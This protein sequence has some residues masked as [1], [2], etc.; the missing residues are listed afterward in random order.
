M[1]ITPLHFGL[2]PL[3]NRV[4]RKRMSE[5][6]FVLAN[7]L[8]DVPVVI[9]VLMQEK[10]EMGGPVLL[11][12]LHGVFTHNFTGALAMGLVLGLLGFRSARWWLGCLLGTMTHVGLDMFV[13]SDVQPFMPWISGNPFYIDG[14]HAV[15]SIVLLVGCSMWV[16]ESWDRMKVS[17]AK[18]R[19]K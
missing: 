5:A 9:N 19:T 13:H 6:A 12:T 7:V 8:T 1:P 18:A 11:G 16:L 2:I 15:F 3:L 4:T 14:A 10:H 17:H